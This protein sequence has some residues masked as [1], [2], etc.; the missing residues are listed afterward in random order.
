LGSWGVFKDACPLPS[1]APPKSKGEAWSD[2]DIGDIGQAEEKYW[3]GGRA[4]AVLFWGV[5][6][7]G[8]VMVP[9]LPMRQS[10]PL[11]TQVMLSEQGSTWADRDYRLFG[12][13]ERQPGTSPDS[14]SVDEW[15]GVEPGGPRGS[16]QVALRVSNGAERVMGG[17]F[18]RLESVDLQVRKAAVDALGDFVGYGQEE[19]IH[20]VAHRLTHPHAHVRTAT[21]K[22]LCQLAPRG[23][24]FALGVVREV[25]QH[26]EAK[27]RASAVE[28]ILALS[29]PHDEELL[30]TLV[31]ALGAAFAGFLSCF[32]C[33]LRLSREG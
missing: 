6:L 5:G 18:S 1:N 12:E 17:I 26:E 10:V 7:V 19:A 15:A 11:I 27:I 24:D 4:L 31:G 32:C 33:L 28:A 23:D 13:G 2:T 22:G 16:V 29:D 20:G 3:W 14:G 9:I 30:D 8:Q 25:M 21:V